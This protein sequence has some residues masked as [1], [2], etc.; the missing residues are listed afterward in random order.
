MAVSLRALKARQHAPP[1]Y[2]YYRRPSLW[3]R[4]NTWLRINF[5]WPA[6]VVIVI[7]EITIAYTMFV[8]GLLIGVII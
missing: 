2:V 4:H 1:R 3:E 7:T 8:I 6:R 5:E